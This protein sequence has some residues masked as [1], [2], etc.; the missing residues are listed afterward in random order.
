MNA[1][2]TL[3]VTVLSCGGMRDLMSEQ[4]ANFLNSALAL[5]RN[6]QDYGNATPRA[7][8]S[9]IRAYKAQHF[10]SGIKA[11]ADVLHLI[12]HANE[13]HLEV[14]H[15]KVAAQE[16]VDRAAKGTL[17]MAPVVVSTACQFGSETWG[18]ALRAAGVRVVVAA[19]SAVTPANLAAFNMAFYAALLSRV[20]KNSS[21]VDR[22]CASFTLADE[23]YRALHAKGTPFAKF[24]ITEL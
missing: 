12:A 23:Y 15:K 6:V 13:T 24:S 21:T 3:D 19:N 9:M 20:R 1:K 17:T 22:V 5:F 16:I 7:N 4:E 10:F 2:Q 14:G 8:V 18:A 11:N